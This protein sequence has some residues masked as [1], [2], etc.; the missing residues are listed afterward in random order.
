MQLSDFDDQQEG[1]K[2][3][4]FVNFAVLTTQAYQGSSP[5]A[6]NTNITKILT[7]E[8]RVTSNPHV[9]ELSNYMP[10]VHFLD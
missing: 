9:K 1:L 6:A 8:R 10:F 4:W 5:F 7:L 3:G 2:G